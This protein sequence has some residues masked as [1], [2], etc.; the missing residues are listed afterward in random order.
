MSIDMELVHRDVY[1]IET[2]CH[3]SR[4]VKRSLGGA[5][6]LAAIADYRS[7]DEVEHKSAGEFLYP[8]TRKWQEQYEWAVALADGVN[9]AWLRGALNTFRD[10]WDRQRAERMKRQRR[11][12]LESCGKVGRRNKPN[13]KRERIHPDG[14]VLPTP[15]SRS[16]DPSF[17]PAR[18][19]CGAG[20]MM[21]RRAYEHV[22]VMAT[23]EGVRPVRRPYYEDYVDALRIL[24][25]RAEFIARSL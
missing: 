1:S 25:A 5:I 23:L 13:E 18:A 2:I 8:R 14:L 24:G 15:S 21:L 22:L 3:P 11:R 19:A 6:L 16:V 7:M 9:P 4:A 12:A 10:K 20:L 17:Q